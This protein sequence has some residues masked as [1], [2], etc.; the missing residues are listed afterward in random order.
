MLAKAIEVKVGKGVYAN[1][2]TVCVG[3]IV[4]LAVALDDIFF[5]LLDLI[6]SALNII[7]KAVATVEKS[8]L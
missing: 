5:K 1:A 2:F 3:F 8:L 6:N 4:L 7:H